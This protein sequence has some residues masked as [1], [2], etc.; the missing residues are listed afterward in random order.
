M[1]VAINIFA[2]Y[3]ASLNHF[4]NKPLKA[5]HYA[6]LCSLRLVGPIIHSSWRDFLKADK[7]HEILPQTAVFLWIFLQI[8]SV[9]KERMDDDFKPM[10][11]IAKLW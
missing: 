9:D 3:E 2:V 11:M 7:A 1:F 5:I 4:S 10:S 8:C 6:V